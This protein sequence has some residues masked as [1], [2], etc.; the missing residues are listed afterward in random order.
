MTERILPNI[1]SG[2]CAV[3][4]FAFSHAS[5]EQQKPKNAFIINKINKYNHTITLI[6]INKTVV[7]NLFYGD[8]LDKFFCVKKSIKTIFQAIKD[9]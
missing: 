8:N 2:V 7:I 9:Q 6:S 4:Q 5:Q 1:V 3:S